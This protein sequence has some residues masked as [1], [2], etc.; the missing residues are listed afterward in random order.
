MS[1]L[2]GL[3]STIHHDLAIIRAPSKYFRFKILSSQMVEDVKITHG[4]VVGQLPHEEDESD[5]E[6]YSPEDQLPVHE[7]FR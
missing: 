5:V 6:E 3:A 7:G 2:A 1:I 4:N